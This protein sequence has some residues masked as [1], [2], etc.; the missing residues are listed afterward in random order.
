MQTN[1]LDLPLPITFRPS[2]VLTDDELMHL[3]RDN[4]PY[5]IERNRSGEITVMTPVGGIGSTHE[6]FVASSL[7]LWSETDGRG[8]AFGSNVGFNLSDGSCLSPDAAWLSRERW[9]TLTPEQ[10][11]DFR[12]SARSSSSKSDR[13]RTPAVYL[14]PKCSFGWR[15]AHSS[16]G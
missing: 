13:V 14:K 8:L 15:T 6:V 1:L 3:S 16:R 4:R 9:N 11:A 2:T 5:K 7:Y 10:Q 12:P